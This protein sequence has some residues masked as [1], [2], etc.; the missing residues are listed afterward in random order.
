MKKQLKSQHM[1]NSLVQ[2]IQEDFKQNDGENPNHTSSP[3]GAQSGYCAKL[4]WPDDAV[5]V[6]DEIIYNWVT[7][8]KKDFK[9]FPPLSNEEEKMWVTRAYIV[10]NENGKFIVPEEFLYPLTVV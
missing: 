9:K 3:T 6:A 10:D 5:A 4:D 7:Y 2:G 1:H 8:N